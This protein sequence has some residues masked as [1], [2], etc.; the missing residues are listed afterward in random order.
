MDPW[1]ASKRLWAA[2]ILVVTTV[3]V[4]FGVDVD[5][6]TQG[7]LA[8]YLTTVGASTAAIVAIILNGWSKF[9]EKKKTAESKPAEPVK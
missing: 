5:A 9:N 4:N 8:E 7:K 1:Y 3:L 6:E 2:G